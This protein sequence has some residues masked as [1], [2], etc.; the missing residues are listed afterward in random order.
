MEMSYKG[1]LVIIIALE[2]YNP[3]GMIRT[4]GEN[5]IYP[6]YIG[7]K[8][9]TRVA[10]ASKYVGK[11]HSVENIQESY[12]CL[13]NEYGQVA[14]KTGKKPIVIFA[15]DDVMEPFRPFVDEIVYGLASNGETELTTEVK[16]YLIG[17]LSCD[18][19]YGDMRRPL[20][21]GLSLTTASLGRCYLNKEKK[22]MLPMLE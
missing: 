13:L 12:E 20:Q 6:I 2:H 16:S 19:L 14:E 10:S 5:G 18:T 8:Y 22:L 15:D 17:V 11:F 4:F 1:H 7:V 9:R 21:L 3:L